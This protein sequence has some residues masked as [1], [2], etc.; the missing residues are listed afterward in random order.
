M[1]RT[2][3]LGWLVLSA[4]LFMLATPA[5]ASARAWLGV[6]TQEVTSDLREALDLPDHGVLVAD[7]VPDSPAARAGL[8]KGDVILAVDNRNVDSPSELSDV[9]GN[10]REGESAAITFVRK[11]S[12]RTLAIRLATRPSDERMRSE[13]DED[14]VAPP[15]PPVPG[16]PH[17]APAPPAPRHE[18]RWYSDNGPDREQ[19]RK[20]LRES[21]PDLENLGPGM[22]WRMMG[23][24]R[25]GV[26]IQTLNGDMASALGASGTK[27]ALVL[28]VLDD[29]PAK[30]AGLRAGD[31]ITAVE[32]K[33][34]AD[35]D[36][37]TSAIR[38]ESGRVSLT[39]VRR[40]QSRTVEAELEESP[41]VLRLRDGQTFIGPG[42]GGDEG[43]SGLR[44]KG[45]ADD[46]DLREQLQQLRE[47]VR[48]LR[49][50][51]Q[52]RNR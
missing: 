24:G 21:M 17:A 45:N 20:Q 36:D 52:D 2:T 43:K 48:A 35:A 4:A 3:P 19:I 14:E 5:V 10:S 38:D 42:R 8:R 1:R 9:I 18:M 41:R 16:A 28:E 27:G 37:L 7:V 12:R 29:T 44:S 13:E 32:G 11:G 50:E 39:V 6:Y 33:K 47:E 51:I 23:R 31:I 26:R 40:G 49:R 30:K 25:L 34:V 46:Q 22:A 15:A